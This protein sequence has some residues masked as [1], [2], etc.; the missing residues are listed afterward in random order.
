MFEIWNDYDLPQNVI[1]NDNKYEINSD[2]KDIVEVLKPLNDKEL[3]DEEKVECACYL[4]YK[5]F[6]NIKNEDLEDAVECMMLFINGNK[7]EES[8]SNEKPTMDWAKDLSIIIAPINRIAGCDIRTKEHFHW[9]TFLSCFMEIGECTFSTFVGI[10]T[11]KNKGKKLESYEEEIYKKNI[12]AIKLEPIYDIETQS[13][14][15]E[16]R[17]LLGKR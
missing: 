14:L 6:D 15:D 4:F 10:R 5:D 3:L 7:K 9:W 17:S 16:I 2:Y 11:K 13:Q 1:I 8:S 12:N